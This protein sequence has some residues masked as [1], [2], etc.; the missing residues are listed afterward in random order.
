[1]PMQTKSVASKSAPAVRA[2]SAVDDDSQFADDE[3]D[4]TE[5]EFDRTIARVLKSG[6][7]DEEIAEA[8][9]DVKAGR[10]LP[11][12]GC[13]EDG[14]WD[15]KIG[16]DAVAGVFDDMTGEEI[17]AY[18]DDLRARSGNGKGVANEAHHDN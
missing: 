12:P 5:D 10:V 16:D 7:L 6:V 4:P 18:L 3:I 14:K 17:Q 1:M 11:C 2:K 13:F 15:D 8:W 9:E